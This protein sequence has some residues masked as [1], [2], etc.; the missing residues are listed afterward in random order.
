MSQS[1]N[2]LLPYLA[3]AQ[4]QKHVTHNEAI[5][6]LDA[7]VQL[8]VLDKDLATPPA[9]PANGDRYIVPASATGA[10]AS[11]VNKLAAYQDGAWA[12]FQPREGWLSWVADEDK[13]Y[14]WSGSAWI[15]AASGGT[16]SVN[17]TPLVGINAT[18]DTTNR[19]S[20]AAPATLL[21]HKGGGH[22]LKLNKAAAT[23]TGTILFQTGF[24]GRAEMGTIGDNSWRLKVSADGATWKTPLTINTAG[25]TTFAG[26]VTINTN[27][28]VAFSST[29][30]TFRFFDS[31]GAPDSRY[32]DMYMDSGS[33]NLRVINDAYTAANS[34]ISSQ[35]SG[36]TVNAVDIGG[37]TSIKG[38]VTPL[39]D[40]GYSCGTASKRWSVVYAATGVIQTSDARDKIVE[41]TLAGIAG[42]MVDAVDPVVFRWRNG[43]V[44]IDDV[45][46][47]V[48]APAVDIQRTPDA[49][50]RVRNRPA[51]RATRTPGQ[52]LHAGFLAQDIK[53]A[54]SA[55]GIDFAA[56]G[57]DDVSDAQSRQ[58]LR[59]DQLIPV[60]WAALKE[61]RAQVEKLQQGKRN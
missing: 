2:L 6:S 45:E 17:P 1:P 38:A 35:R 14:A 33:F 18:A 12:F 32:Y 11:H 21:N 48:A 28:G 26:L 46:D 42:R 29:F 43:G 41:G 61:T 25:Q 59:P 10:W 19:L 31:D 55:A 36:I 3:A 52:R 30:P 7:L 39:V 24:S 60:L 57:L 13:L 9:A 50:A 51:P 53:V 5:R 22:Q 16:A 37:P 54:M 44:R 56:W 15:A 27:D 34:I 58:H 40:N 8:S 4:A 49:A 23:D 20:V 47:D